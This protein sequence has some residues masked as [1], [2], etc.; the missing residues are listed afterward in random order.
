MAW[1]G[2]APFHGG[3]S[4]TTSYP[5]CVI[6]HAEPSCRLKVKPFSEYTHPGADIAT[7]ML[8]PGPLV[9]VFPLSSDGRVGFHRPANSLP[10]RHRSFEPAGAIHETAHTTVLQSAFQLRS[11]RATMPNLFTAFISELLL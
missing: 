7:A 11:S 1:R 5:V 6:V 3:A 2:D 10:Y 4:D 8:L 9:Q